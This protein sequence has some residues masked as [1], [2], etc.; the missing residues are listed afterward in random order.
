MPGSTAVLMDESG[1]VDLLY[2]IEPTEMTPLGKRLDRAEVR[3]VLDEAVGGCCRALLLDLTGVGPPGHVDELIGDAVSLV[4]E[5]HGRLLALTPLAP[6]F[7]RPEQMA[8]GFV[9]LWDPHHPTVGLLRK[10][11]QS[12]GRKLQDPSRDT[13]R[14]CIRWTRTTRDHH[15]LLRKRMARTTNPGQHQP[16][17][18]T[19]APL[20]RRR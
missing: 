12:L 8:L 16:P 6:P 4:A 9:V 13:S 10:T 3:R 1:G 11:A 15:R 5:R 2:V 17:R 19:R 18:T 7:E 14:L 20:P